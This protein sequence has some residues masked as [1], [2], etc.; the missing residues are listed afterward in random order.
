MTKLNEVSKTQARGL[1]N[2]YLDKITFNN[3]DLFIGNKIVTARPYD[4]LKTMSIYKDLF[5]RTEDEHR[6]ISLTNSNSFN[7]R[8]KHVSHDD[9]YFLTD[10]TA[11]PYTTLDGERLEIANLENLFGYGF[12]DKTLDYEKAIRFLKR[13][14]RY[15]ESKVRANLIR[16]YGES[17]KQTKS[18]IVVFNE[19]NILDVNDSITTDL[20]TGISL[21]KK[22]EK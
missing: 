2:I 14:N 6:F 22:F 19:D 7:Q 21:T 13:M 16:H 17:L 15:I 1:A 20:T 3:S 8:V 5:L 4:K 10:R 11:M 9:I 18:G 12:D